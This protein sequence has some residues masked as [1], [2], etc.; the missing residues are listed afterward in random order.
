[1]RALR[2]ARAL[3]QQQLGAAAGVSG[4][5]VGKLERGETT[6]GVDRLDRLARA[7]GVVLADLFEHA[8]PTGSA[9][10]PG[11]PLAPRSPGRR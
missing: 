8:E 6:I 11:S 5:L 4:R 2:H 10:R 1:L 9:S 3:S 7:L